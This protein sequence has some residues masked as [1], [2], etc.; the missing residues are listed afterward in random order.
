MVTTYNVLFDFPNPA[1]DWWS[2]RKE[3]A[4]D[5][6][7]RQDP[8]LLGLQEPLPWQ[9][10]TL[11]ELLPGYEDFRL[12]LDTDTTLFYRASRFERLDQGHAWLSPT[13]EKAWST[14][15]GN[16]FPRNALWVRLRDVATGIE[17]V[18]VNTHFDNTSPFQETAAPYYLAWTAP[19]AVTAPIVHTGDYNSTPSSEAYRILAGGDPYPLTN[20][21]DL[22]D[23]PGV[24]RDADDPRGFDPAERI[25]HVFVGGGAWTASRWTV[26]MSRYGDPPRDPSDHFAV[27][28]VIH[29]P[30]PD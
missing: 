30:P 27:T 9:V 20:A 26:D 10:D 3:H 5:I 6:V 13:P 7:R 24:I 11:H 16:T 28:A 17:L 29:L 23:A 1:F 25:D 12:E 19:L 14:G 18:W 2:V 8:D 22:V 4:A 15:W 21:F